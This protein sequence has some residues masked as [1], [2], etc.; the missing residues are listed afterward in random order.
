[1]SKKYNY[2]KMAIDVITFKV[3]VKNLKK[4]KQL[5]NLYDE[6]FVDKVPLNLKHF[7]IIRE[8]DLPDLEKV[9]QIH[10][11]YVKDKRKQITIASMVN[12]V[13]SIIQNAAKYDNTLESIL[14]D[15][16]SNFSNGIIKNKRY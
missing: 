11:K 10:N 2:I 14:S 9:L 12:I 1:M 6:I 3:K 5:S 13:V 8:Y 4:A 16:F 15:V 7:K